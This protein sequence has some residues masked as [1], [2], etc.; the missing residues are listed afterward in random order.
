MNA[1]A[2]TK[3]PVRPF[4]GVGGNP[5]FR[6]NV[7]ATRYADDTLCCCLC[8]KLAPKT[9]KFVAVTTAFEYVTKEEVQKLNDSLGMCKVGPDCAKKLQAAGVPVYE[10]EV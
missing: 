1:T 6:Q 7:D 3:T 4:G 10:E 2:P 8:G 5:R 9:S